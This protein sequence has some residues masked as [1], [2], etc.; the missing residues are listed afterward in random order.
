MSIRDDLIVDR[1]KIIEE[2]AKLAES[3]ISLQLIEAQA[4]RTKTLELLNAERLHVAKLET[5]L[6]ALVQRL[7]HL[8]SRSSVIGVPPEQTITA[9]S[10]SG[11]NATQPSIDPAAFLDFSSDS[12]DDFGV[13]AVIG[14]KRPAPAAIQGEET[15]GPTRASKRA[16]QTH[17]H[18]YTTAAR[19]ED[20]LAQPVSPASAPAAS[21]SLAPAPPPSETPRTPP[22]TRHSRRQLAM[23]PSSPR[24][25]AP[26]PAQMRFVGA[27]PSSPTTD[28]PRK[29]LKGKGKEVGNSLLLASPSKA[30]KAGQTSKSLAKESSEAVPL[31]AMTAPLPTASSLLT[32]VSTPQS[33]A[34]PTSKQA[35]AGDARAPS[36]SPAFPVYEPPSRYG[37]RGGP[38]AGLGLGRPSTTATNNAPSQSPV[39]P[40]GGLLP[41]FSFSGRPVVASWQSTA[42]TD[43]SR[44]NGTTPGDTMSTDEM[45]A[46]HQEPIT[47][48]LSGYGMGGY[49]EMN[50]LND[51]WNGIHG[52]TSPE[53]GPPSPDKRT[54]YGTE[55]LNTTSDQGSSGDG[56]LG[57][58]PADEDQWM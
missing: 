51:S 58:L 32:G 38:G 12:K 43:D 23:P 4:E 16:R 53:D 13:A 1:G 14:K 21:S 3:R 26:T 33:P 39:P 55:L 29:G 37:R 11:L 10:S 45:L 31:P 41:A 7:N 5:H 2:A 25:G 48:L 50:S 9:G 28:S 20:A 54:L 35:G 44:T 56:R 47:P 8:E 19:L 24:G 40:P 42:D 34:P 15:P 6:E 18:T 52:L 36:T 22:M 30:K 49:I 17:E 46:H 57:G 27:A